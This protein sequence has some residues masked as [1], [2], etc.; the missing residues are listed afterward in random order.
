MRTTDEVAGRLRLSTERT[1]GA[2]WGLGYVEGAG[3]RWRASADE[4]SAALRRSVMII[5]DAGEPP[6]MAALAE[7]VRRIVEEERD[8]QTQRCDWRRARR[9]AK[10]AW[11]RSSV[12]HRAN[13]A[14][15]L[16]SSSSSQW[17]DAA[18]APTRAPGRNEVGLPTA[19]NRYGH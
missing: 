18:A 8:G 17:R 11:S 4:A 7:D 6:D 9:A 13:Q 14:F 2:L 5:R 12:S 15:A 10:L 3:G 19:V 16:D 1:E